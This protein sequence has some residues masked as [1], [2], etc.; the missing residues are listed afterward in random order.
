MLSAQLGLGVQAT[1]C[2]LWADYKKA[3]KSVVVNTT[4]KCETGISD[5]HL[6]SS[7]DVS[8]N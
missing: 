7:N 6:Y 3:E 1:E 8:M 5:S 2:E 4:K